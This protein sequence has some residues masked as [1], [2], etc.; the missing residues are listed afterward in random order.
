MIKNNREKQYDIETLR[1]EYERFKKN[2]GDVRAIRDKVYIAFE[3]ATGKVA[4][5]LEDML[6]NIDIYI[7]DNK[8]ACHEQRGTC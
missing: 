4:D 6:M 1:R 7:A 3:K 8:C 5:E 2:R